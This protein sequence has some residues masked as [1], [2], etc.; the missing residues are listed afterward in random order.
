[1]CR[2]ITTLV[3]HL[4]AGAFPG[5]FVLGGAPE[6]TWTRRCPGNGGGAELGN[7]GAVRGDIRALP[8]IGGG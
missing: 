4:S 1:M 5:R 3:S 8:R 2:K 7:K 6:M